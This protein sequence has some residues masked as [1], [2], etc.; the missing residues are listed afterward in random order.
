MKFLVS[1]DPSDGS[2]QVLVDELRGLDDHLKEH[3]CAWNV[4]RIHAVLFS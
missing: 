4:V 1:N 3:V 2:E